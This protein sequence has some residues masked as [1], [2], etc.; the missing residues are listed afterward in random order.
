MATPVFETYDR[1][2]DVYAGTPWS[3]RVTASDSD[4]SPMVGSLSGG[5]PPGFT[6]GPPSVNGNEYTW[7][8]SWVP[9]EA[10]ST[11]TGEPWIVLFTAT[12]VP[13]VDPA[14]GVAP[15]PE[16]ATTSLFFEAWNRRLHEQVISDAA[17]IQRNDGAYEAL[18]RPW[19]RWDD[20][21]QAI[22]V[23][24]LDPVLIGWILWNLAADDINL[25]YAVDDLDFGDFFQLNSTG[26]LP[27]GVPP[28]LNAMVADWE[29]QVAGGSQRLSSKRVSFVG[30]AEAE[31]PLAVKKIPLQNAPGQTGH[32]IASYEDELSVMFRVVTDRGP[33][34]RVHRVEQDGR[35]GDVRIAQ[36]PESVISAMGVLFDDVFQMSSPVGNG[37][38]L[39]YH[40]PDRRAG[41]RARRLSGDAVA[42]PPGSER[43]FFLGL[44]KGQPVGAAAAVNYGVAEDYV[45][46]LTI[47]GFDVPTTRLPMPHGLTNPTGA[48]W[49][50]DRLVVVA[51]NQFRV[52]NTTS[53]KAFAQV[54]ATLPPGLDT[55]GLTEWRDY[56]WGISPLNLLRFAPFNAKVKPDAPAVTVA[57]QGRGY[58]FSW[59]SE[60]GLLYEVAGPSY[61]TMMPG[62]TTTFDVT[63]E[64]PAAELVHRVYSVYEG[65][66]SDPLE[67]GVA[68]PP[69]APLVV[70]SEPVTGGL[71]I[72][73][74]EAPEFG[75]IR[76]KT[77]RRLVTAGVPGSW[78]DITP[79]GTEPEGGWPF[80]EPL[81]LAT[82]VT[83]LEVQFRQ[84][85]WDRFN[86][87]F[88]YGPATAT[89]T[90]GQRDAPTLTVTPT[91]D[92]DAPSWALR[93]RIATATGAT[94]AEYR[95]RTSDGGFG[96][97]TAVAVDTDATFTAA[98]NTEY[99][100]EGRLKFAVGDSNAASETVLTHPAAPTGVRMTFTTIQ[101]FD[102][103]RSEI[104]LQC[105]FT[106]TG[107]EHQAEY[108][109]RDR[110][111]WPTIAYIWPGYSTIGSTSPFPWRQTYI[112]RY[113]GAVLP[114]GRIRQRNATGWGPWVTMRFA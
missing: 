79:Q 59:T 1:Q 42:L 64:M 24:N 63:G 32:G 37:L 18:P 5:F 29:Y 41:W 83:T 33:I 27:V 34:G 73:M 65:I 45:H 2:H 67:V 35:V 112:L 80:N 77:Q 11:A 84:G 113:P 75:G 105:F 36:L 58:R 16:S 100:V 55:Q 90:I 31:P 47:S 57:L 21:E 22:E 8:L 69:P 104:N 30:S 50:D 62:S 111:R 92:Y 43:G 53:G 12:T 89:I 109:N 82:S 96:S 9:N 88:R 70:G 87:V 91:I 10:Q 60:P 93:I 52:I 106:P 26:R 98:A 95:V 4:G 23:R 114:E 54:A 85:V 6:V 15:P 61:E 68:Y 103:G 110:D 7:T 56:P 94:G 48:M 19:Y 76:S 44:A 25:A 13:A 107:L 108:Q 17:S 51:D 78:E 86:A 14:T 39:Y 71:Q 101:T 20:L 38:A 40:A 49:Y 28:Q 46:T 74:A 3:L 81:F 102:N 72:E 97:W 99:V 66:R